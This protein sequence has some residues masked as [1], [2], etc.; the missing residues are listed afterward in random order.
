MGNGVRFD[1]GMNLYYPKEQT[2]FPCIE[3]ET[4]TRQKAKK[5]GSVQ[6]H[7]IQIFSH[8]TINAGFCLPEGVAM[9]HNSYTMSTHGLP[10]MYILSLRP[11]VYISGKP[12]LSMECIT[13]TYI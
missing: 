13:I 11:Q 6:Q 12:L 8:N 2:I 5:S 10:D 1:S 7:S 4:Q 9:A 3:R